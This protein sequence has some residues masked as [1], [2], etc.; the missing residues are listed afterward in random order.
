MDNVDDH[1][2]Q[3]KIK[4]NKTHSCRLADSERKDYKA[5]LDALVMAGKGSCLVLDV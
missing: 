5:I 4:Q 1:Q 3:N 2:K